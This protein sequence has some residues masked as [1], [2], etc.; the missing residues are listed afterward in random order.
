MAQEGVLSKLRRLNNYP[1]IE[2][3]TEPTDAGIASLAI[4]VVQNPR[5]TSVLVLIVLNLVLLGFGFWWQA[6]ALQLFAIVV[7]SALHSRG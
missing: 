7:S 1:T 3:R 4:Q 6:W 5:T 2:V